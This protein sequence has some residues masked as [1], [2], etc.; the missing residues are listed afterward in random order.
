M[1]KR[2]SKRKAK[3][4]KNPTRR[5]SVCRSEKH[6]RRKCR[7]K[8]K[9]KSKKTRRSRNPGIA[10]SLVDMGL[11]YSY[12]KPKR[13]NPCVTCGCTCRDTVVDKTRD[14]NKARWGRQLSKLQRRIDDSAP[15]SVAPR[16]YRNPGWS[17]KQGRV[18][19]HEQKF[20]S[21]YQRPASRRLGKKPLKWRRNS[22]GRSHKTTRN[23]DCW[24]CDDTGYKGNDLC[25]CPAGNARSGANR[26]FRNPLISRHGRGAHKYCSVDD[27]RRNPV[28]LP[29]PDDSRV[30]NDCLGDDPDCAC[31][32]MPTCE[33]AGH[34]VCGLCPPGRVWGRP[35]TPHPEFCPCENCN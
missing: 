10:N 23:P 6:D 8:K 12:T 29:G 5:C 17:F 28:Y 33:E 4:R 3:R 20:E 30:C 19:P 35:H 22:C 15:P 26:Y 9:R 14:K 27:D 11:S 31:R 2:K 13:S 34:C 7:S 25:P 1:A 21:L 24:M 32:N 16:F 18:V